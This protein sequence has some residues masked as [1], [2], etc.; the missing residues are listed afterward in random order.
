MSYEELKTESN[1][2]RYFPR[3]AV[4]NQVVYQIESDDRTRM[5]TTCDLSCAGA[6]ISIENAISPAQ[7]IRLTIFLSHGVT[8]DLNGRIV[9]LKPST[10]KNYLGIQFLN[11]THY[12][13][14]LILN[15][16]FNLDKKKIVKSWF[17]G[18]EY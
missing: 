3:W 10:E 5:G 4:E 7:K 6:C 12:A 8:V 17:K 9:W 14:E 1:D 15:H 16:A 11:T 18:W 13:Q 2:S